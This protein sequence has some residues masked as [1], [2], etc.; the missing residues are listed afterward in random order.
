[1]TRE[2]LKPMIENFMTTNGHDEKEL[3][4][5]VKLNEIPVVDFHIDADAIEITENSTKTELEISNLKSIVVMVAPD[6]VRI[7]YE[8][9]K[10]CK[11]A[12]FER[13]GMILADLMILTYE[14]GTVVELGFLAM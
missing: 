14:N 5:S 7:S 11:I 6:Y 1:M 4:I 12:P 8:D 9:V 13:D 2:E 3:M 10:S